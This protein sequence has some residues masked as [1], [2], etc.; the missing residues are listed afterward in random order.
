[1]G[2][3]K[4]HK[5][6]KKPSKKREKKYRSND[7]LRP[8]YFKKVYDEEGKYYILRGFEEVNTD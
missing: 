8:S 5:E 4:R 7:V 6:I 3:T 1:M 2:P